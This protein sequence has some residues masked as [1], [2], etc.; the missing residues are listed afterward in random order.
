MIGAHEIRPA[1]AVFVLNMGRRNRDLTGDPA[2][3]NFIAEELVPWMRSRYAIHP[4]PGA[5]AVGGSSFGGFA[6]SYTALLHSD[7]IGN[8]ISQSG[9]YWIT[10]D[11][12][13]VRPP[14]PH[15]TGM[16]IEEFKSRPHLPIRFYLEVGRFD[17]GAALLGANRELRDVLQVKGY[18][19]DYREFDGGHDIAQ[20]RSSLGDALIS[21]FG[22]RV[23]NA[24]VLLERHGRSGEE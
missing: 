16:L 15:D 3:A 23:A 24:R 9:A 2:F 20:W 17:L 19:V 5:V 18:E 14:Y 6:A 4:G 21:I 12:Q 10:R 8:V 1:I 11:W 7:V 22:T 13:S